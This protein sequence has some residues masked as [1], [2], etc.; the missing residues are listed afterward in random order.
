MRPRPPGTS[1]SASVVVAGFGTF[2]AA[3]RKNGAIVFH[4]ARLRV[5]SASS[6]NAGC[7]APRA[8]TSMRKGWASAAETVAAPPS[9]STST[10]TGNSSASGART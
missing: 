8:V 2:T 4:R 6:A 9:A 3:A 5:G 1:I 10:V 7:I